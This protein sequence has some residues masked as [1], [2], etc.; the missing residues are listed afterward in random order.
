MS[1]FADMCVCQPGVPNACLAARRPPPVLVD[2]ISATRATAGN[3]VQINLSGPPAKRGAFYA[4]LGAIHVVGTASW[5]TTTVGDAYTGFLQKSLLTQWRAIDRVEHVYGENLD[6]RDLQDDHWTRASDVAAAATLPADLADAAATPTRQIAWSWYFGRPTPH[7]LS[8]RGA[9]PLAALNGRDD[10]L[11]FQVNSAPALASA[12]GVTF[13][14]SNQ[15]FGTSGTVLR[16]YAEIIYSPLV[17]YDQWV[18]DNYTRTDLADDLPYCGFHHEYAW[19][20]PRAEDT[21]GAVLTNYAGIQFAA[22]E[23]LL[24]GSLSLAEASDTARLYAFKDDATIATPTSPVAGTWD[25][26]GPTGPMNLMTGSGPINNDEGPW[27]LTGGVVGALPILLPSPRMRE[28]PTCELSYNFTAM[29][30]QTLNRFLHRVRRRTPS[31]AAYAAVRRMMCA[32]EMEIGV[33]GD[34]GFEGPDGVGPK[35]GLMLEAA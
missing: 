32:P 12:N 25:G 2:R 9:I 24:Y 21:A 34:N 35:V 1:C 18:L 33:I 8:L 23:Q 30:S 14:N 27:G 29:G 11:S 17:M 26:F 19:L 6:G 22:G 15:P 28:Q 3:T 5:T 13:T 20:R 7:G 4:Y 16:A 31:D 10:A